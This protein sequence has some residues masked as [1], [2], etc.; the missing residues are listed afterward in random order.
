M[1]WRN[2]LARST[3]QD[4]NMDSAENVGFQDKFM[5]A[6]SKTESIMGTADKS[7]I[8]SSTLVNSET[9]KETEEAKECGKQERKTQVLMTTISILTSTN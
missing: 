4:S 8:T 3:H 7:T 1:A 2:T 5:K 9:E 6:C